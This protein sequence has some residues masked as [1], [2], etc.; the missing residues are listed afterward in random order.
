MTGQAGPDREW[1]FWDTEWERT[2]AE[3]A[4]QCRGD[5]ND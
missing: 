4:V 5:A 3:G 2:E 1:E